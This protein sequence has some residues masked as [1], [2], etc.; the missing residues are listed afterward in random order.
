[1]ERLRKVR[2]L[3]LRDLS[4][5]MADAG[6]PILPIGL[7]R[8]ANGRRRVDADDLAALAKVLEVD[9]AALLVPDLLIEIKIGAPLSS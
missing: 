2:G 1:V 6:R 3:S 7:S 4:A 5:R 9:P 8:M